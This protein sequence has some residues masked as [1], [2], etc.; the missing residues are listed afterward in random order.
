MN[1]ILIPAV[2]STKQCHDYVG[3][4]LFWEELLIAHPDQLQPVRTLPRGDA[5]WRR[6]SVDRVIAMAEISGS[7]RSQSATITMPVLKRSGRRFK[8]E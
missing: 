7:L 2:L 8:K 1:I 4:R 3:G 6:E 5:F